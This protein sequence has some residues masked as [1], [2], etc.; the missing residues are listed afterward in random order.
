[1]EIWLYIGLSVL[2]VS[3][4]PLIGI[5]II[6]SKKEKKH[7]LM[8]FLVSLAVGSLF[9]DAI[10]HLIPEAFEQSANS[11]LTSFY[12]ILGIMLFFVLEKFFH[13]RHEH[14][15]HRHT[16]NCKDRILPVGYVILVSDGLHNFLDGL[17][18]GVSYFA[19]IEVGIATT[20]AVILHEIPQEIG[21]IGILL[22]AGFSKAR[23]LLFN[24]LTALTAF[25]GA[26]LAILAAEYTVLF[27]A[28][29]VPVAAGGFLY[30]AGSD[31]VPELHKTSDVKK[32]VWQFGG[33]IIGFSL[34]FLLLFID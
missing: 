27:I 6:F 21:D 4:I 31:L 29:I 34:M 13:W 12:I 25:I 33:M 28:V 26:G 17:V 22:H 9:G 20:L 32:S 2:I 24:L 16:L 11:V 1:M 15:L 7:F 23:A 18:I 19:G 30:I 10:I 8:F 5:G 3:L 14:E